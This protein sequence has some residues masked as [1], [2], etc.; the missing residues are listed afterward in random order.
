MLA[1]T[2]WAELVRTQQAIAERAIQRE[3]EQKMLQKM[4]WR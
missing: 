2:D 3:K 1:Q 4:E